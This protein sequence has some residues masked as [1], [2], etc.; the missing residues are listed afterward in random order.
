MSD[1]DQ[2]D[3][4][5]VLAHPLRMRLLSLLT[6]AAMSSAEAAR[7]LG[8]SQANVSYH[9]RRLHA[10]GLLEPAGET[11]IRGGRAKRYRHDPDSAASFLDREPDEERVL[12]AALA[13]ELKRRAAHRTPGSPAATTDAELWIDDRVWRHAHAVA[14][15][16][17][18]QLHDAAK[19]PRTPGTRRISATIALFAVEDR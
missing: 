14:T 17:G 6:G 8:E 10:A 1:D 15:R 4:L 19:P 5:R 9:L 16:L 12:L 2:L 13:D 11:V 18:R 7:E 3:R